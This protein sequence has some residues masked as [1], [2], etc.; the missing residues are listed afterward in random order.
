[1][2]QSTASRRARWVVLAVTCAL[3][4]AACSGS[5]NSSSSNSSSPPTSASK[6]GTAAPAVSKVKQVDALR[7]ML[8][9][10]IRQRGTIVAGT[11]VGPPPEQFFEG[12]DANT[13]I[14]LTPDLGHAL[15]KLF[16]V[17]WTFTNT[18]FSGIIPALL[19]KRFD[20]I[21]TDLYDTPVR[22]KQLDFVDYIKA[23]S[24]IAVKKDNPKNIK[25]LSDLCG[26]SVAVEKA[27]TPVTIIENYQ[28]KC[29]TAGTITMT[30]FP[31]IT[32]AL[33]QVRSGRAD[34]FMVNAM[35]AGY[36]VKQS[37]NGNEFVVAP[38][39]YQP[40]LTGPAFRKSDQQLRDAVLAGMKHLISTGVY[41]AILKYWGVED[42]AAISHPVI[43]GATNPTELKALLH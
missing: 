41:T 6:E 22:Q 34:A 30:Q 10:D 33:L 35:A 11:D 18:K 19:A 29:G 16:G 7:A 32:D 2:T 14:G 25:G 9:A 17:K 5:S 21:D 38:G 13:I 4:V 31:K 15:G 26:K 1:M 27:T 3:S 12:S 43:N 40:V 42:L 28:S 39:T 23:A 37:Q 20:V 36:L 24:A 8:P